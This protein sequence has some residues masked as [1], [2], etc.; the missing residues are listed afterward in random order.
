MVSYGMQKSEPKPSYYRIL[1]TG[2]KVTEKQ[3]TDISGVRSEVLVA[4]GNE[5]NGYAVK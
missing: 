3:V 5:V 1:D 2:Y 4:L